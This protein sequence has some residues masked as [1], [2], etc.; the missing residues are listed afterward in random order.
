MEGAALLVACMHGHSCRWMDERAALAAPAQRLA[1][2]TMALVLLLTCSVVQVDG[3][4]AAKE[5]EWAPHRP[6]GH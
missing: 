6:A 3:G 5:R 1:Q 2:G 4:R